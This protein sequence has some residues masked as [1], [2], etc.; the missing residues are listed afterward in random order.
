VD[1]LP[2]VGD[3]EPDTMPGAFYEDVDQLRTAGVAL[4]IGD[5]F[6]SHPVQHGLDRFAEALESTPL[7]HLDHRTVWRAPGGSEGTNVGQTMGR[8]QARVFV[9][10]RRTATMER[11]SANVIE[12]SRSMTRSASPAASTSWD[13]MRRRP[14]CA[15]M[16]IA[17]TWWAT[18]SC[19]SRARSCIGETWSYYLA[20]SAVEVMLLAVIVRTAWT[21][22]VVGGQA[23]SKT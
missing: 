3:G 12:A 14:A 7:L 22:P 23:T 10:R 11:I 18:V 13:A 9:S 15:W 16:A 2:V 17:D 20:G 21:W 1:T 6:P 4:S 8:E 5:G 19:S